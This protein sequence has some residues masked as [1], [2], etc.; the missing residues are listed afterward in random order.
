MSQL[1]AVLGYDANTPEVLKT[2]IALGFTP[3]CIH[4]ANGSVATGTKLSMAKNKKNIEINVVSEKEF[5]SIVNN[6]KIP[7]VIGSYG[8]RE[9]DFFRD[10]LLLARNKLKLTGPIYHPAFLSDFHPNPLRRYAIIGFPGSGNMVFQNICSRLF[11]TPST[12]IWASDPL[13]HAVSQFALCY[14]YSLANYIGTA[15]DDEGRWSDQASPTHMRFGALNI[16]LGDEKS[17]AMIAGL[18]ARSYIW[19]NPWH[20]SHEPLTQS[21]LEFFSKQNFSILQLARH[22]LDL[23]VSNAAKITALAGERSPQLLLQNEAW[24]DG[25]LQTVEAYYEQMYLHKNSKD[26]EFIKYEDLLAE[27]VTMIKRLSKILGVEANTNAYETI[28]NELKN[29]SLSSDAGHLWDPRADKWREYIPARFAKRICKSRLREYATTFGYEL[30]ETHFTANK[31]EIQSNTS[32][33]LHIAWRDAQWE[34]PIG[35]QPNISHP[36]MYRVNDDET[37]LLFVCSSR[38]ERVMERLRVSQML[39]DLL[40][41]AKCKDWLEPSLITDYLKLRLQKSHEIRA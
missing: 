37:G 17:T 26:V 3:V 21:T 16:N 23:I 9:R 41:A 2:A 24:M 10:T 8:L 7:V 1:I 5:V 4:A 14:W 39:R 38:Y 28:W 35:K 30:N 13:S 19:S 33:T 6:G 29:T 31:A 32:D 34:A 20:T 27:P 18:P 40:A 15:F 25:M 22:P 36:D 12:P 11:P